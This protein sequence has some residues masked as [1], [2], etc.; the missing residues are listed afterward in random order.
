[1]TW[2]PWHHKSNN[3]DCPPAQ[4]LTESHS[5][6]SSPDP[7]TGAHL[8][9]RNQGLQRKAKSEAS[10]IRQEQEAQSASELMGKLPTNLQRALKV[11]SE[12]VASS[13]LSTLPIAE[14]GFALH[15]G[16]FGDALCLRYGW[17]PSNLPTN[18]VCGKPFSVE[19][20]LNCACGGLPSICHNELRDITA[21]FLTEVCYNVGTEPT[22]Q[23]L[24]QEQ[25]K[26]KTANRE[27]VARLDVV[28]ESFWGRNRQRAFFHVRVFNPM[29]QS[30]H[31]TPLAHRQNE[32]E[33]REHMR[34]G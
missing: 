7:A 20:A 24:S 26:Q 9:I 14:H 18:C 6:T 29:A 22:L 28:T 15:K 30:H 27:D 25:L 11:S 5:T 21:D 19:H 2:W 17:R 33:R 23:S 16:A 12:K 32:Q 3:A 8:P 31:N 10:T 4:Y 34:N 13:W 1:M